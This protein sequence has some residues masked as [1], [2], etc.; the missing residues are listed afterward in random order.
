[1]ETITVTED[2]PHR[3]D[4]FMQAIAIFKFLKTLLFVLAA[5][6]AFGLMQQGISDRARE[7]GSNLAFTT[8]QHLVRN[9]IMMIT[10]LSRQE[11]GALGLVALFYAA[12]F[13]TEG[14]GLWR[15]RRWA[16]YLTAIATGSLIPFE[17]YEIFTRPTPIKFAT[18]VVNVFVVIYLIYR[19]RR[20]RT[21]GAHEG[22]EPNAVTVTQPPEPEQSRAG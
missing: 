11:I 10:G 21:N 8:G 18:F 13:G 2:S 15:E 19:L 4:R 20:P 3:H 5:L 22:T 9:S 14:V 16:E 12:L 7:W 17:I 1:M 6:G